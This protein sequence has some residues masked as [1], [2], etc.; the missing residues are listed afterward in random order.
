MMHPFVRT[1]TLTIVVLA[2]TSCGV[3]RAIQRTP[4]AIDS[5]TVVLRGVERSTTALVPALK[6]VSALEG[7]L[8]EVSSLD[9]TLE[10]VA[11]LQ[12]SLAGVAGLGTVL[13]GADTVIVLDPL[14][15]SLVAVM[16]T[17]PG[18]TPVTMPVSETAVT[19]FE[20]ERK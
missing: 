3:T 2:S 1:T 5:N 7:P 18:A 13:T 20:R 9:T 6:G 12:P 17:V 8:R 16:M 15:P 11:G 14:L 10:R 19:V 4:A